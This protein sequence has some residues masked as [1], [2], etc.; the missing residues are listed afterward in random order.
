V[1]LLL[2]WV[3]GALGNSLEPSVI[4]LT[5]ERLSPR[6]RNTAS[7]LELVSV[8]DRDTIES[9]TLTMSVTMPSLRA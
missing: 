6:L 7:L 1:G 4:V 3:V 5:V 8:P 9:I 2:L